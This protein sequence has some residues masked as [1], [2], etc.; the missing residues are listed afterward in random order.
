M[1]PCIGSGNLR[2]LTC[3]CLRSALCINPLSP[4]KPIICSSAVG[5]S[6]SLSVSLFLLSSQLCLCDEAYSGSY[7]E[8]DLEMR[9]DGYPIAIVVQLVR[10][11]QVI[12]RVRITHLYAYGRVPHRAEVQV[13]CTY[14]GTALQTVMEVWGCNEGARATRRLTVGDERIIFT[15][16]IKRNA[17]VCMLNYYGLT[18]VNSKQW[19]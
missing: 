1:R 9:P 16:Q 8:T 18:R 10:R 14:K 17:S 13:I 15:K 19:W 4:T 3:D 7:F 11:A 2:I 12:A 5:M 6:R